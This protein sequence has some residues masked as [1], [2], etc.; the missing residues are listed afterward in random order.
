MS[1]TLGVALLLSSGTMAALRRGRE[2]D[3]AP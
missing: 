2:S 1:R 3:E